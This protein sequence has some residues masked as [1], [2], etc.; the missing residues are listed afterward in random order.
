MSARRSS[1]AD[2]AR[3]PAAALVLLA[4][5]GLAAP[6]RARADRAEV[7]LLTMGPGDELYA[8]F[9]HS[10]LRVRSADGRDIVYNF[11]YTRFGP[12][13][14]WRVLRGTAIFW[15][16]PL[17][18]AK[19]VRLYARDNRSTW[20]QALSL[21]AAEHAELAALLELNA[22]PA[23]REYRYHH[24]RDN[25]AT[26]PRDLLDRVTGGELRRQLG[27]RPS[28]PRLRELVHEG[29]A[30]RPGLLLLADLLLG[31]GLDAPI[32]LWQAGFLPRVL[33][34]VLPTVK[35][36]D[37]QPLAGPARPI[38]LRRKSAVA[39]DPGGGNPRAGD[40]L[41]W[42]FALS[43]LA[44]STALGLLA[45][46]R[47]R[48]GAAL[49]GLPAVALGLAGLLVWTVAALSSSAELRGNENVLLLWPTDLG[50]A[51]VA[52]RWWR[53]RAAAGPLLRGY[54]ALRLAVPMAALLGH[55]A[56]A[57]WQRPLSLALLSASFGAGLLLACRALDRER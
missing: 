26:R 19:T 38:Y 40:R 42:L 33:L 27:S 55:A 44:L 37:G 43:G 34:E 52:V 25:C 53:G 7:E 54:A 9:G 45:R 15:V 49:L 14:V 41:L 2:P 23:R 31:R 6:G 16:Q 39:G 13:L 50:L 46:P 29:L 11:G 35:R 47:P 1:A 18:Y 30:G 3:R 5:A 32:S 21:S 24:F 22:E 4:L 12:D 56:G 10:A 36:A 17:S 57:L 51:G 48:L 20:R 8:R 28:G